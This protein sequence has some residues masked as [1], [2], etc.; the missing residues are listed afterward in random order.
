M[1]YIYALRKREERQN[2]DLKKYESEIREALEALNL[3]EENYIVVNED[4]FEFSF[5]GCLSRESLQRMGKLLVQSGVKQGGFIRQKNKAYAFLSYDE[6]RA[7]DERMLVELVDCSTVDFGNKYNQEDIPEWVRFYR[8]IELCT[9]CISV[10]KAT[11]IFDAFIKRTLKDK[12]LYLENTVFLV[13]LRH[14]HIKSGRYNE[15]GDLSSIYPKTSTA[16]NICMIEHLYSAGLYQIDFVDLVNIRLAGSVSD[17]EKESLLSK[18]NLEITSHVGQVEQPSD[19]DISDEDGSTK[20]TFTVHNVGQALATS[21]NEKG[22]DPFFYFDYGIPFLQ[23]KF[24]LPTGTELRIAENATILLS[25][26]HEDHWCGYRLNQDALKCRW[27]IPQNLQNPTKALKK[28]LS[29]VYLNGGSISLYQAAGLNLFV[30]KAVNNCMVAGNAQSMIKPSRAPKTVHETGIALY[31]FAEHD[32]ME[33]KIHVS[34]DQDYD[35][36]DNSYI[37]DINLL[38]ACHHGGEY[39]WSKKTTVPTPNAKE[40]RIIYSYG[41][42]NTHRHP[43]MVQDYTMSGWTAEHHT[44]QDGDYEIDLNLIDNTKLKSVIKA[45]NPMGMQFE[46]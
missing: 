5:P 37:N 24:T 17:L 27:V 20:Y 21:L 34:G 23:N 15:S 12:I 19:T 7:E 9:T 10:R 6:S 32:S 1:R 4:S 18:F 22:K 46:I 42:G 35:Y 44:P 30:I 43:S 38:V 11:N 16:E 41:Q 2:T 31:I 25:H 14:Y 39:S 29:S 28:M 40:N 45:S 8:R 13:E 26:V 3:T 33:Y 36:Q